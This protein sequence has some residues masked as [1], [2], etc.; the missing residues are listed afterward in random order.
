MKIECL[1]L[2]V[3]FSIISAA[4]QTSPVRD[5]RLKTICFNFR[6]YEELCCPLN[7]QQA[8]HIA[9]SLIKEVTVFLKAKYKPN[10]N[11]CRAH[12]SCVCNIMCSGVT[13]KRLIG[14]SYLNL[15]WLY[16]KFAS[17]AKG[18]F[19]E[20]LWSLDET[21]PRIW[22]SQSENECTYVVAEFKLGDMNHIDIKSATIHGAATKTSQLLTWKVVDPK[23]VY[24]R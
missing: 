4:T 10:I 7:F 15:S 6:K 1:L 14:A 5:R 19:Y 3:V 23:K 9:N 13:L 12:N 18:V 21:L 2:T 17:T 8:N 24:N 16:G 20:T 11:Q 22:F